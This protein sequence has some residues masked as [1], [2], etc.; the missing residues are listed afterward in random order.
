MPC[1]QVPQRGPLHDIIA[2]TFRAN[3]APDSQPHP[4]TMTYA[5]ADPPGNALCHRTVTQYHTTGG[6]VGAELGSISFGLFT[7][8]KDPAATKPPTTKGRCICIILH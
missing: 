5:L 2:H 1:P 3:G 7:W 6:S 8:W 4:L